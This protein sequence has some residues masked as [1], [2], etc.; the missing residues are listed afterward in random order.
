MKS[1]TTTPIT[2]FY[3]LILVFYYL[4]HGILTAIAHTFNTRFVLQHPRYPFPL[5]IAKE[6]TFISAEPTPEVKELLKL[7]HYP[8]PTTRHWA[9]TSQIAE[10][11]TKQ[12][13]PLTAI[14]LDGPLLG[15][16]LKQGMVIAHQSHI[17]FIQE[18][19]GRWP[20]REDRLLT[21]A[22][23]FSTETP[24]LLLIPLQYI[25]HTGVHDDT[26]PSP[27]QSLVSLQQ[28]LRDADH[29]DSSLP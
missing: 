4:R 26:P 17:V 25:D 12:P 14:A 29:V 10:Q 2:I 24:F 6:D 15:P 13:L 9:D 8:V 5:V 7:Q 28:Y 3:P 11:M 16:P 27:F 23:N 18:E 22:F 21:T 1:L 20:G 19:H